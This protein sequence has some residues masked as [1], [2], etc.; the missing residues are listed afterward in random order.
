MKRF[1]LSALAVGTLVATFQLFSGSKAAPPQQTYPLVCR[2]GGSLVA[3]VAPGDRNIGFTFARG[4]KPAGE[5][6]APGECSWADRGMY[7]SEPDRVSQHLEG[8]SPDAGGK[9]APENSWFE[10]LHSSDSYWTFMVA[11]NGRGQLIATS[12][13]RNSETRSSLQR[14][15]PPRSET[16]APRPR[17]QLE[18]PIPGGLELSQ[19][20]S[21]TPSCPNGGIA[22]LQIRTTAGSLFTSRSSCFPYLCDPDTK[23][24]ATGCKGNRDCAQGMDCV[25]GQCEFPRTFCSDRSTSANSRGATD[26]CSP[27]L[28]NKVTGLCR[29]VCN[30]A[31]DC[32]VDTG[33]NPDTNRCTYPPR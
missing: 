9:L 8:S 33:C 2:G 10:E 28:C 13:R 19:I 22:S 29:T 3:G 12:A 7:S 4:T 6:L 23:T 11:N 20:Q 18:N 25:S 1:L 30:T 24:C 15:P 27:F 5:G 14:R 21:I 17:R 32:T 26:D 31:A 16:E